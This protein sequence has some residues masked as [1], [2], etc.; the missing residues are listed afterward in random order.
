MKAI[1]PKKDNQLYYHK[2]KFIKII[3]SRA[4]VGRLIVLALYMWKNITIM[5]VIEKENQNLI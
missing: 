3:N 5:R 2:R 4:A 1:D